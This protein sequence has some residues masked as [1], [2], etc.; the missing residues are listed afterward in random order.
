M[1]YLIRTT[2]ISSARTPQIKDGVS[3]SNTMRFSDVHKP[4]FL[5]QTSFFHT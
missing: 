4:S 2:I 5:N 3:N 1:S